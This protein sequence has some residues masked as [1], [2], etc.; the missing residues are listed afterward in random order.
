VSSDAPVTNQCFYLLVYADNNGDIGNLIFISPL[1]L[2]LSNQPTLYRVLIPGFAPIS[3]SSYWIGGVATTDN[4]G[5]RY[6]T[7]AGSR[8][9]DYSRGGGMA[10]PPEPLDGSE[11]AYYDNYRYAFFVDYESQ[12]K[13]NLIMHGYKTY[14]KI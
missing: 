3:G 14:E 6:D 10:P 13:F 7:A 11:I 9:I 4:V 5:F 2:M 8:I 1:M 12:N